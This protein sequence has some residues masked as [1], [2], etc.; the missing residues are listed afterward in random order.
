MSSEILAGIVI[1]AIVAGFYLFRREKQAPT[2]S[3]EDAGAAI[4]EFGK[5]YPALPIRDVILT[6]DRASAFLRLADGR[7]GVVQAVGSNTIARLI[8]PGSILV[9]PSEGNATIRL[10]FRDATFRNGAFAFTTA[11]DA[12]EVSLW[13]VGAFVA[14]PDNAG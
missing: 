4:V 14:D 7:V 8:T 2:A 5:A 12:A 1:L 3:I 9:Q 10:D 13:L 11:Q 6:K